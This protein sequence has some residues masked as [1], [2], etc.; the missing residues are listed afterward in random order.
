MTKRYSAKAPSQRQKRVAEFVR[1]II[2]E[3]ILRGDL[4]HISSLDVSVTSVSV[5]PDLRYATIYVSPRPSGHGKKAKTEEKILANLHNARKF[6][7]AHLAQNMTSRVCPELSFQKDMNIEHA[8]QVTH[9]L[10]RL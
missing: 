6:I 8:T 4:Q 9:T 7:R 10:N 5:S 1:D 2:T 3:I